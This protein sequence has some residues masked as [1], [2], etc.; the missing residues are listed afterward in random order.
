MANAAAIIAK[1]ARP[2][3]TIRSH[4]SLLGS[5]CLTVVADEPEGYEEATGCRLMD[6]DLFNEHITRRLPCPQCESIALLALMRFHCSGF[7]WC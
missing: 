7:L 5:M 1:P 3:L 4:S 6:L 2:L